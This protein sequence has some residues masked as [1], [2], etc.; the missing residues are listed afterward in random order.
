MMRIVGTGTKSVFLPPTDQPVWQCTESPVIDVQ[1]A[2]QIVTV[3][4]NVSVA[5]LQSELDRHGLCLPLPDPREFG[6]LLGGIPG[7]V[8][9]LLAANLPHGL[10]AQCGGSRQWVLQL[11]VLFRGERAK[12]G[13]KVV[14]SVAGYDVHKAYVGSWG[15]LGPILAATLRVRSRA[16]LPIV[17]SCVHQSWNSGDVWIGR[18]LPS[19]FEAWRERAQSVLAEDVRSCTLWAGS[20]LEPPPEGWLLGPAG[21]RWTSQDQGE[22]SGRMKTVFDPQDEWYAP[23]A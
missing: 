17:E 12:S 2:D 22:L 6:V 16:S 23:S 21:F 18:T 19:H 15:S 3:G 8:G 14:K 1:A 9:G 11:E 4:A 20:K 13:A 5:E 10:S 7:T